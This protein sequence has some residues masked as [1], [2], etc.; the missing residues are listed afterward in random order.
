MTFALITPDYKP[1]SL[2]QSIDT[3]AEFL[4]S[5][6][7]V[8]IGDR[9]NSFRSY[10]WTL[11]GIIGV[12]YFFVCLHR[13]S[14]TVVARDLALA[15]NADAA[16]LGLIALQPI[17]ISI[18]PC[19]RWWAISRL[20]FRMI[21]LSTFFTGGASLLLHDHAESLS[22]PVDGHRKRLDEHGSVSR[23]GPLGTSQAEAC[24]YRMKGAPHG[25]CGYPMRGNATGASLEGSVKLGF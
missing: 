7:I 14:P 16:T 24:G 19:S 3:A 22:P 1:N 21:F 8:C 12:L 6:S 17:F 15:F 23:H 20:D 25:A 10:R 13:L 2:R 5:S 4:Y 9:M 11:L 18:R